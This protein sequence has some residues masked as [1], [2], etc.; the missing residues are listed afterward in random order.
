MFYLI[1]KLGATFSEIKR[2]E[3]GLKLYEKLCFPV[4]LS[5]FVD[6]WLD[7]LSLLFF[8]QVSTGTLIILFVFTTSKLANSIRFDLVVVPGS[9]C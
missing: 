4:F 1:F 5:V 9:S 6:Y 3:Y 2:Y 8:M 7:Q